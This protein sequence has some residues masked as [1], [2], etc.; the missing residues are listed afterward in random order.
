[1]KQHKMSKKKFH[2]KIKF[3]LCSLLN[4]PGVTDQLLKVYPE[5]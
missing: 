3:L 2:I 5:M 4:Q 1:M